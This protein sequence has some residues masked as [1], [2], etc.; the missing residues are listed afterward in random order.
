MLRRLSARRSPFSPDQE[1]VHH[2][3]QRS[4]FTVSQTL[5]VLAFCT[6]AMHG[7]GM[8]LVWLKCPQA[9]Q[10]GIF[11]GLAVLYHVYIGV[12]LRS[13]RCFGRTLAASLRHEPALEQS[14]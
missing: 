6:I 10:M 14:V 3:L 4:G 11:L 2:L 7:L 1:H 13:G 8:G 12:A 5:G 9:L